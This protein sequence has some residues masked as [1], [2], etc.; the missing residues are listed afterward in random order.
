MCRFRLPVP[1][2]VSIS[3]IV[4]IGL[5][6]DWDRKNAMPK[7]PTMAMPSITQRRVFRLLVAVASLDSSSPWRATLR[8]G[9]PVGTPPLT[10]EETLSRPRLWQAEFSVLARVAELH[11]P[12]ARSVL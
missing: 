12:V 1:R 10:R 7:P 9:R 5:L 8:V 6:I 4:P 3:T 2:L 11:D